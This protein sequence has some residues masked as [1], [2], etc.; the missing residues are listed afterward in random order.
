MSE[1]SPD[2]QATTSD[3]IFL[4]SSGEEHAISLQG[5]YSFTADW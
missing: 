2:C 4:G 1:I 5:A 3:S